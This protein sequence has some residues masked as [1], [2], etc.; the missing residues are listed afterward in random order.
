MLNYALFCFGVLYV[1]AVIACFIE[2]IRIVL[3]YDEF[4][5]FWRVWPKL[6]IVAFIFVVAL[7]MAMSL[8]EPFVLAAN[9]ILIW[10]KRTFRG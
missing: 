8:I 2:T 5:Q 3:V 6:M 1:A 9:A 7:S 4:R 10:I